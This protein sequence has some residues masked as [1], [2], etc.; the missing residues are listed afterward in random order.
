M[1]EKVAVE[2]LR[3]VKEILDKHGVE[4]WLDCGTL[5]GAVRDGKFIPWD[6]DIDL[7]TLESQMSKIKIVAKELMKYGLEFFGR[8]PRIS[9]DY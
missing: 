5:L 4:Y 1:D 2:A 9:Q 6:G 8:I 3:Q 7:G